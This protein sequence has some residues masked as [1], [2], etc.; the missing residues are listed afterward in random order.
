MSVDPKRWLMRGVHRLRRLGWRL[1]RPV[2]VGARAIPVRE[3]GAL[4]MVRHSYLQGWFFPGGGVDGGETPEQAAVR[5]LAEETGLR[6]TGP[7]RFV[8]LHSA[9]RYGMSDHVA[10]YAVPVAGEP[11]V[12]GWEIVEAGFFPEDALPEALSPSTREQLALYLS[13]VGDC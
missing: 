2:K 9:F 10:V 11:R 13:S 1:T 12:D 7:A 4:C 3:D 6:P 5:E 8:A